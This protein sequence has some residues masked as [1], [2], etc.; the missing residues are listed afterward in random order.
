M[1]NAQIHD[2]GYRAYDGPRD[3][4]GR[5]MVSLGLHAIQRVLGLKRAAR[6]KVLPVLVILIAFVPAIAFMGMAA[7]LPTSLIEEDILPGHDE[8]F[9]L[10]S[11][12]IILFTSFV[13]PEALCTDR[14]TGMF[15]LYLASPL[16][17]STYVVSK[18]LAVGT[19]LLT[20]TLLPQLFLLIAYTIE[21]AGP[22]GVIDFFELLARIALAGLV[23]S[24][25]FATL[26][27]CVASFTP[28]RG[29]ASAAIVIILL[30]SGIVTSIVLESTDVADQL[31]LLSLIDLPIRAA[32]YL[33][34]GTP[35][36]EF[37][38]LDRVDG[39]LTLG[40]TVGLSAV[41]GSVTW[42]RY[43]N[44]EVGQ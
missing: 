18:V 32:V 9:G 25:F 33:L 21:G 16:D 38:G 24:L 35:D 10:I 8:Y 22:D 13:A 6:H 31:G 3:G 2:L 44:L 4:L 27:S 20:I 42:W 26:S 41:F 12:A 14:R 39:S 29:I 7:L 15:A 34:D 1:S 5:A 37:R 30:V 28:R 43:Q 11:F 17:R 23:V 40:V 36:A 19:V